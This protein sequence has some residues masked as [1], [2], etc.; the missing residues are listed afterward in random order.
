M[1]RVSNALLGMALLLCVA[2]S[3]K[4]IEKETPNGFKFTVVKAG[5]GILP[6][7]DEILVFDHLLKDSKDSVWNDTRVEGMPSAVK[8]QDSTTMSQE[9]GIVQMFR[10]LSKGDS[11]H[12]TMPVSK[13]F[14]KMVG[15]PVPPGVDTTLNL[16]YSLQVKDIMNMEEFQ[17]FQTEVMKKKKD[18][19]VEKDAAIITKYLADNNIEAQQ[20][21]SGLRY[22]IHTT[23]GG[24]KPTAENCV[25]VKYA[26][27]FLKDGK[28]FDQGDKVSFPLNRVIPGWQ[29]GIQLL[30]VGDS[31]TFYI[32]S[33]LAYGPQGYPGA[34]P[35]DAILIFDVELL[36]FG[37]E[38]DETTGTCK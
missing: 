17:S 10:M 4:K 29:L 27:K 20:D 23:K 19:Q 25:E 2:C 31:A 36:G 11:V 35:P 3:D 14:N 7:K 8:I 21:T 15:A 37:G 38:F 13:F 6:K 18:S 24:S 28:V 26:G 22:I 30:G 34:I 16:S 12:V 9:N 32:P 33:G 1:I 5:D